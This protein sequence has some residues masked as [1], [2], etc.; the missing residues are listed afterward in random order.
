M[1]RVRVGDRVKG[2]A[3]FAGRIGTVVQTPG[4]VAVI[5]WDGEPKRSAPLHPDYYELIE[6]EPETEYTEPEQIRF[7][8][9]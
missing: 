7:E 1:A 8:G 9:V 2:R 3:C 4:S 6:T 5:D